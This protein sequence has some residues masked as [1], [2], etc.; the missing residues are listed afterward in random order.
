M[1]MMVLIILY[2]RISDQRK[3]ET[4]IDIT[5]GLYAMGGDRSTGTD[6]SYIKEQQQNF[7][8]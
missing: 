6:F 2:T 4:K 3:D 1:P 5:V 8:I 7:S